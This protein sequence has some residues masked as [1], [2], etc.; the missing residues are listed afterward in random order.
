MGMLPYSPEIEKNILSKINKQIE[1]DFFQKIISRFKEED[2]IIKV[3]YMLPNKPD[4]SFY[5]VFCYIKKGTE[6]LTIDGGSEGLS[7]RI[8]IVNQ[9]IFFDK[10]SEYT[11]NIRNQILNAKDCINYNKDECEGKV[12]IFNYNGLEYM[13]CK[14][15]I[16]N[17]CFTNINKYDF[18]NI[19]EILNRE[20][21]FIKNKDSPNFT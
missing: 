12:Y 21:G 7:L 20:T 8:R 5:R 18:A 13:K 15:I 2:L 6:A 10:L 19:M 9:K 16:Y 3:R 14:H 1:K 17:F 4:R 11:E